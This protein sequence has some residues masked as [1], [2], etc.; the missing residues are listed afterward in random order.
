MKFE[1]I[2]I[3]KPHQLYAEL[4][5]LTLYFGVNK[6]SCIS[7]TITHAIAVNRNFRNYKV[8][9]NT[10]NEM[11][12]TW[13]KYKLGRVYELIGVLDSCTRD[14]NMIFFL[15]ETECRCNHIVLGY[16]DGYRGRCKQF[17][18]YRTATAFRMTN[19]THAEQYQTHIKLPG[20]CACMAEPCTE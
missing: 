1:G 5:G 13:K 7:Q 10:W 6:M 12:V 3:L 11:L 15:R 8:K 2:V 9:S 18:I 17:Y 4:Y 20:Y 14:I 16:Q 19:S